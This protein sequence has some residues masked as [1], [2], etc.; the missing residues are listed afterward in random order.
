MARAPPAPCWRRCCAQSGYRV[1][2][3][4]SPHLLR[5]NERVRI[6]G[7]EATDAQLVAAF[8]RVE[9][10]RGDTSLTYFEFG[11]LAAALLF[12]EAGLEIAILEVGLGGRLDAVNLFDP[13]CAVVT[14]IGL[15]HMDYLGP[16]RES[17]GLEK[18]GIFRAGRPAVVGDADPPASL[19]EHAAQVGAHLLLNERDFGASAEAAPVD[20]LECARAQRRV[21]L[22]GTARRLSARE[23]RRGAG[24]SR[25]PAAEGAD[26]H[27][28]D[29]ARPGGGG[30]ARTLPGLARTPRRRPGRCPQSAGRRA[31]AR[32]SGAH[33]HASL[34]PMPC[35]G[36]SRTRTSPG[37]PGRWRGASTG[38]C[39]RRCRV[40]A[41]RLPTSCAR[42][43]ALQ[44][45]RP[46]WRC[47]P[48]SPL[49]IGMRESRRVQMIEYWCSGPSTPSAMC[50][51][52]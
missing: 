1:G 20:L 7:R 9:A 8:E 11:T 42:S 34:R 52:W 46:R 50:W 40:P 44:A 30:A 49:P 28:S 17:I 6:D 25:M 3:Y 12:R 41:V 15:D 33:G 4:T 22:A 14:S 19:L 45:S 47:L 10:A 37:W 31:S 2:L 43:S 39:L 51:C 27:G 35:S 48:A 24:R 38:G 32:E 21:A 29:P 36:C 13:D 18:A 5:Y 26:R 23:R 16:T